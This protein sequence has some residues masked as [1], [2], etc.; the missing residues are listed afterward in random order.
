MAPKWKRTFQKSF[1]KQKVF[2][3][4]SIFLRPKIQIFTAS[5]YM[6]AVLSADLLLLSFYLERQILW[7]IAFC[8]L[9][10]LTEIDWTLVWPRKDISF[11]EKLPDF[12]QN[13]SRMMIR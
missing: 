5:I 10:P 6:E 7:T 11:N 13:T 4:F 3:T 12:C 2:E 1:I 8:D 9:R